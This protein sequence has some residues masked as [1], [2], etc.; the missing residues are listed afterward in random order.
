MTTAIYCSKLTVQMTDILLQPLKI[1]KF[2][3]CIDN[4]TLFGNLENKPKGRATMNLCLITLRATIDH[5]S[6][7]I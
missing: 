3:C 5:I 4:D 1:F 2:Y 7:Y 6:D